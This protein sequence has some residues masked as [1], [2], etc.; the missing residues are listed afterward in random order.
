MRI[1]L[2]GGSRRG[3]LRTTGLR[4]FRW[5]FGTVPGP[6]LFFTYAPDLLA[7]EFMSFVLRAMSANEASWSQGEKEL[8]ATFVSD[9][10]ACHF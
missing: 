4:F 10:N 9:L 5:I 1:D 6:A 7:P 2:E 3:W 8:L